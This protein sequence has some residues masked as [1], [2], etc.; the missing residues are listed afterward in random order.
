[1]IEKPILMSAPMVRAILEGRKTQ[2]RRGIKFNEAGRI[3]YQGKQWHREDPECVKGSPYGQPGD[4]LWAREAF[5][6]NTVIPIK[7][8]PEGDFIYMA[9]L[10]ERGAT[11]Y[12]AKWKPS[13]HMPRRAS[14]ITLEITGVR[15]ER[16]NDICEDDAMAEGCENDVVYLFGDDGL[17]D[18]HTGKYAMER[19]EEL[20][21]SING[22]G[23]WHKNPWVWVIEF[24]RIKL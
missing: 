9:D 10:N 21:E 5:T 7:D 3:K 19:F 22:E 17:P 15:V 4:R 16:L 11:K 8:R 6:E 18:W 1:M 23:S 20:W 2:T 13:I 24:E 12:A 14:R